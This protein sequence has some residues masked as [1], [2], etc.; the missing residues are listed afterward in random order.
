MST[1][2]VASADAQASGSDWRYQLSFYVWA[3]SLKGDVGLFTLPTT[4]VDVPFSDVLEDPDGAVMGS[5]FANNGTWLLIAD[6]VYAELS[7]DWTIDAYGGGYLKAGV[8]QTIAT[9]AVGYMLP[10]GEPDLDIA[11]T[12]GL[13]YMSLKGSVD[14]DSYGSL[15]SV[16]GSQRKWWIDPTIGLFAQWNMNEKWVVTAIADIGGF[17]VGSTLSSTG[18]LG[19]GYKWTESFSTSLGYRYLYEDYASPTSST[20]S[21]RYNTTMHGPTLAAAWRF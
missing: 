15:P 6:L 14:F 16:V 5:F 2:P 10:S 18:Y 1:P 17:G 9:G 19:M 8:T 21:F 11:V 20:G 4:S 3:T 12:A 13:R 7:H